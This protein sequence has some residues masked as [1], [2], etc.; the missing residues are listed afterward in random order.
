[1]S[2]AMAS[3][4]PGVVTIRAAPLRAVARAIVGA[5]GSQ[6]D[7]A[8]LVAGQLVESNL[9]GHDSHGVGLLPRYVEVFRLGRLRPNQHASIAAD[10]GPLLTLDG[11]M[12]YG[13]VIAYEAMQLG[14]ERAR[15]WGVA[16]VALANSHHIGRI[17]HWAE[18]CVAAGMVSMHY[19]NAISQP[20]VAPFGGRDARFVTNPFCVGLPRPGGEPIVLDFATSRIAMGKVRLARNR[21][22]EVG[23]DTLLDGHGQPTCDPNV[24]YRLPFGALLPF[25]EHKGYG[26]AVIC[27]LLGGALTGGRTLHE[28][29]PGRE[30]INNMLTVIIDPQ[31]LGTGA[32]FAAELAQF[33]AWVKASPLAPGVDRVRLPGEPEQEHRRERHANGIPIDR[34]TWEEIV[35]AGAELRLARPELERLAELA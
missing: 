23:P 10:T 12:G 7:E 26:L 13:Q 34:I 33:E 9:T 22:V 24:M 18:Q 3:A 15:Q 17:G 20:V 35:R 29:T 32:N 16:V 11:N 14:I 2:G 28:R 25:G 27:E 30:V 31:R 5:A 1:M 6:P 19:V 21:G 4:E 8:A